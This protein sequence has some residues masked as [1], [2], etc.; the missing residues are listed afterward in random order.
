MPRRSARLA[1]IS[2][3]SD[4]WFNELHAK[5]APVATA[6][7]GIFLAGCC[8]GPKD[9]PDTVAQAMAAAGEAVA[10]LSKGTVRTR[11]E[12]SYI[13]PD[14]CSG[15]QT[16]IRV[17]P[18]SAVSFDAGR[19]VAEVN[20]ALCKGCGSCAAACPSSA[21]KVKHFTDTQIMEELESLALRTRTT[22]ITMFEKEC[23]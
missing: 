6:N 11:A 15:C 10:L 2:S 13:D 16:C 18:Y 4:G 17:C 9:I 19:M 23:P 8:Q 14:L 20:E 12:I 5:L 21:A 22:R 3:D 7:N 1:G